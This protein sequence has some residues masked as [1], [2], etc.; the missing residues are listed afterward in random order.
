MHCDIIGVNVGQSGT[1]WSKVGELSMLV[2]SYNHK[3]DSKGRTVLPARFRGE[4]GSSIVATIGIDRCI[5]LYPVS[6][7]EEL[8]LKLKDLSSFKKKTRDFR[9]V[10]LSMATELEIDGSG[11]VLIPSGLREYAG[12]DQEVTLIGL[13]DHLEIWDSIRWEEQRSGV[14]LDFSDLAED[15]EGI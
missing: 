4:L 5:A 13:E 12:V 2:G 15:L 9:R 14:L 3:L 1:K 6:R 11:R 10:L 7:W 8:I